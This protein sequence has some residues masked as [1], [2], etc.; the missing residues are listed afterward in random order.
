MNQCKLSV[1]SHFKIHVFFPPYDSVLLY[2]AEQLSLRLV[3][4][5][6]KDGL[7]VNRSLTGRVKAMCAVA[8]GERERVRKW[9]NERKGRREQMNSQGGRKGYSSQ[10]TGEG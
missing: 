3:K 4:V 2:L 6:S 10:W 5:T 7:H 1:C 8:H 9:E